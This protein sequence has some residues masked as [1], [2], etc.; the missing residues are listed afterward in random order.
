[1]CSYDMLVKI[2]VLYLNDIIWVHHFPFTP[3]LHPLVAQENH[4]YCTPSWT[5]RPIPLHSLYPRLLFHLQRTQVHCVLRGTIVCNSRVF[6]CKD[7]FTGVSSCTQKPFK[8]LH[9]TNRPPVI[10]WLWWL[11]AGGG[12]GCVLKDPYSFGSNLE[13]PVSFSVF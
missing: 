1:M 6:V 3:C 8:T 11:G 5:P 10:C 2:S 13:G 7:C 9:L 4:Y 12:G